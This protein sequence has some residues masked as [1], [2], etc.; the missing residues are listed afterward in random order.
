MKK[1]IAIGKIPD[2]VLYVYN[3][4]I[5][6]IEVG[7]HWDFDWVNQQIEKGF[8]IIPTTHYNPELESVKRRCKTA[9]I[10]NN[11][12]THLDDV[13]VEEIDNKPISNIRI[14]T[15]DSLYYGIYDKY[16]IPIPPD[17]VLDTIMKCGVSSGVL[18]AEYIWV[19]I[20]NNL[21]LVRVGSELHKS[22]L[23]SILLSS[24]PKITKKQLIPNSLYIDVKGNYHAYLGNFNTIIT[25]YDSTN[26]DCFDLTY[27]QYKNNIPFIFSFYHSDNPDTAFLDVQKVSISK[28]HL[29]NKFKLVE[30]VGDLNIDFNFYPD[31]KNRTLNYVK[32][33]IV[34][35]QVMSYIV[36]TTHRCS[37]ILNMYKTNEPRPE[38][39]DLNKYIMFL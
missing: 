3:K 19:D 21:Q 38:P 18:N 16:I 28:F 4:S 6:N 22:M 33:L 2:K 14:I 32:S 24:K 9:I 30:R 15:R 23:H 7:C 31:L 10:Q 13:I 36:S 34:K 11:K 5:K 26:P 17:T 39:F 27:K 20:K 29:V 35:K 1:H 25:K 12:F 37:F 8:V